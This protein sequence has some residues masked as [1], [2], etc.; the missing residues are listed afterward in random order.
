MAKSSLE[1]WE[2]E[3]RKA[4]KGDNF[5]LMRDHMHRLSLPPEPELLVHGTVLV[6]QACCAYAGLD[7]QPTTRFLQLQKYFP[8]DAPAAKYAFTFDLFGKGFA[9][10]LRSENST[11]LDLADLYGHPWWEY[12]VC[13]YHCFWVSRT[14]GKDLSG[15]ELSKIEREVTEDLRFDY[16]DEELDF[17]FDYSAV[18]GILQVNL[19]SLDDFEYE[20]ETE[21]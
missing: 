15:A 16:A 1:R 18:E 13:G 6:V 12:E 17:W 8:A 21:G 2:E 4:A 20:D 10:V 3:F 5:V 19:Q 9:R 11:V 14:D 7:G